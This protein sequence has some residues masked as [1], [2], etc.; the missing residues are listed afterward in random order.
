VADWSLEVVHSWRLTLPAGKTTAVVIKFAPIA[1]HYRM[2][3]GDEDDIAELKDEICLKPQVLTMLQARLKGNGAWKVTDISLS[4]DA[5]SKWL[6]NAAATISVQKP[7]GDAVVSFCG[8]DEK[9]AGKVAVLGTAPE[10]EEDVRI[11][12]FEPAK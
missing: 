7:R 6:D 2:A 12:I 8:M 9:T 1:A 3:K 10:T 4:A 5:P 11:L